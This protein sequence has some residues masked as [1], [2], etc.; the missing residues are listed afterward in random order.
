MNFGMKFGF[1]TWFLVGCLALW[2]VL[3]GPGERRDPRCI[4]G[5]C[6]NRV[7][8]GSMV[9]D[10]LFRDL[11]KSSGEKNN[12]GRKASA[13]R[14]ETSAVEDQQEAGSAEQ[15][16]QEGGPGR[17]RQNR[18]FSSQAR[19]RGQYATLRAFRDAIGDHWKSTV[20]IYSENRQLALGAVVGE[21][22]WIIT[23][24]SEIPD[25]PIEIRF[26]DGERIEAKVRIR[27]P[28]VDLVLLKAARKGLTAIQWN[29][30]AKVPLGGWLAS[31]DSRSLPVA[32]GVVSVRNRSIQ[33]RPSLLGIQFSTSH[34]GP[35]IENVVPGSGA[36]KAGIRDGDIIFRIEGKLIETRQQALE[37]LRALQA[38]KRVE[39]EV[40]RDSETKSFQAQM[41]DMNP[42]VLDSTEA[43]VNGKI[44][45][46]A[47]GFR[48]VIQHDTDLA[49]QHCGGPVIDVDG[50]AVGLNIARAGRVH[51]YALPASIVAK[52]VREMIESA[53]E[54]ERASITSD[55]ARAADVIPAS[56]QTTEDP[57][58]GSGI[59]IEALK[60]VVP[61]PK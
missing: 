3:S 52:S 28:D 61:D 24:S 27:R 16:V 36:S 22:G 55:S 56:I 34:Q 7:R 46:R 60:P 26:H 33:Q 18:N 47:T 15:L 43:D 30:E 51:C 1:E 17:L 44:S 14:F 23:K 2:A 45:A 37:T 53:L 13:N 32:L 57:T 39:I 19:Q 5:S 38:G 10:P 21:D 35:V 25:S 6:N 49:P 42:S 12:S 11:F 4:D 40:N 54:S 59:E 29:E 58:S 31:A 41:T 9:A 8:V 48:E 50:H 20:Q